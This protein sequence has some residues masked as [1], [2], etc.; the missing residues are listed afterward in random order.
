[1][2]IAES[3]SMSFAQMTQSLEMRTYENDAGEQVVETSYSY[4]YLEI[5]MTSVRAKAMTDDIIDFLS[6]YFHAQRSGSG[7]PG[8]EE[9]RSF[10]SEAKEALDNSFNSMKRDKDNN[11]LPGNSINGAR[12]GGGRKLGHF[13]NNDNGVKGNNNLLHR[14]HKQ[15]I[16]DLKNWYHNGGEPRERVDFSSIEIEKVS[17]EQEVTTMASEYAAEKKV[18]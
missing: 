12:N 9:L 8:Q 6:D 15:A 18:V 5:N 11:L 2:I 16:K 14:A 13:K 10:Y 3:T 7:N 17:I 1:M 4:D